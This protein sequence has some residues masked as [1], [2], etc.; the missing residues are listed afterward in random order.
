MSRICVFILF[1]TLNSNNLI[2]LAELLAKLF[3]IKTIGFKVKKITNMIAFAILPGVDAQSLQ[4][5]G[6]GRQGQQ[7]VTPCLGIRRSDRKQ[8]QRKVTSRFGIG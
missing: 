2:I 3:K 7:G 8:G 6:G 4:R 5:D 1:L